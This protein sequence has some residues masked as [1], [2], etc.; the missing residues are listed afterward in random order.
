MKTLPLRAETHQC[1]GFLVSSNEAVDSPSGGAAAAAAERHADPLNQDR[2]V[3]L[4]FLPKHAIVPRNVL[5]LICIC[6]VDGTA[7]VLLPNVAELMLAAAAAFI[8]SVAIIAV[9]MIICTHMSASTHNAPLLWPT[10]P[11]AQGCCF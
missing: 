7:V 10:L 11:E 6:R 2:N 3:V 8:I 1:L 5:L 9:K 4:Y